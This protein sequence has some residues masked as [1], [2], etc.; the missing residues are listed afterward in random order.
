[1]T[2]KYPWLFLLFLV[3]VPLIIWYFRKNRNSTPSMGLSTLNAFAGLG[4]S[5]KEYLMKFNFIL[6][7]LAI[8]FLIVALCR[9]Q[10]FDS[11]RT[12]RVEGTDIILALDISGSMA[13]KDFQPTRFEAAKDVAVKFVN[14]RSNDNMGLVVF[15]GESLSLMPL[16]YDRAALINS[17][18]N[19]ELGDLT[20]GTAIGDGLASAVNR[21]V[22]GKAKSKSII[23]LTD[24]TNNAG[25]VP[26]FTAAQ[27]A[28]QNGIKV[29]TIGVGTDGSIQITDPYGFSTT[30]LET[31]IDE[32]SLKKIASE[33]GGK[34]FRATDE[35]M[36]QK[37]IKEI[38]SLEKTKLDVENFTRTDEAFFPWILA[39][40]ICYALSMLFRYTVLR[41]I[42]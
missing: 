24:G 14:Q 38:D 4:H 6:K 12:S 21:L 7:L 27:I 39:A 19:V 33:T 31:K 36:L 26:P 5:W 25:E 8:G 2:F 18:Q 3:Y 37:V 1:M 23:L 16:T 10:T 34:F 9:P 30:T 22:S 42:P 41:R 35:K 32:T 15:A 13:S 28:R 17:I 20:D 11:K 29:Y 40:F